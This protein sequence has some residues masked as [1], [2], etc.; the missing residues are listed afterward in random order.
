MNARLGKSNAFLVLGPQVVLLIILAE[1]PDIHI[2]NHTVQISMGVFLG[3]HG[4]FDGIHATDRRAVSVAASIGVSG[5]DAL[6]PGNLLGL[7]TV[8]GP[9]EMAEIWPRCT[10]NPFEFLTG[11]DVCIFVVAQKIKPRRIIP[12]TARRENDRAHLDVR[13]AF[14]VLIVDGLGQTHVLAQTATDT[15]IRID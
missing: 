1:S 2:E 14:G 3:D 7:L 12:F 15:N 6:K 9:H 4:L 8:E 11:H 13:F 5:T 10:Q